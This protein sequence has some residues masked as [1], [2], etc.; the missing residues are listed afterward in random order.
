M[1]YRYRAY[2]V[3]RF[4]P[5]F[6][7]PFNLDL[8][9][10]VLVSLVTGHTEIGKEKGRECSVRDPFHDLI[11]LCDS[12]TTSYILVESGKRYT[13]ITLGRLLFNS[14]LLRKRSAA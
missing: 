11:Y 3:L 8:S 10:G 5:L 9:Q 2:S 12:Y 13:K 6:G 4:P 1:S 7:C 14:I